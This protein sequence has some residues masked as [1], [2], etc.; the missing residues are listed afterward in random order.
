MKKNEYHQRVNKIAA[1]LH[2]Y[3]DAAMR[4]GAIADDDEEAV[5]KILM[6][7]MYEGYNNMNATPRLVDEARN[8][9]AC[10]SSVASDVP[11][12]A[13][14]THGGDIQAIMSDDP[15]FFSGIGTCVIDLDEYGELPEHMKQITFTSK[16]YDGSTTAVGYEDLV[17]K[18]SI[19]LYEVFKQLKEDV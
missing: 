16:L 2:A 1:R 15:V 18:S 5:T 9:V 19:E 6:A 8:I 11:K 10:T 12:L 3:F 7:A 17:S 13:V 14:V 4:S